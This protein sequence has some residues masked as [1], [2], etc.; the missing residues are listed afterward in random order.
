MIGKQVNNWFFQALV[1]ACALLGGCDDKKVSPPQGVSPKILVVGTSADN[2]PFET[3]REGEIVGFDLDLMKLVAEKLGVELKIQDMDLNGLI[4]ALNSGHIDVAIAA[5]T[6]SPER[7]KSVDFSRI[8][9]QGTMAL[10]FQSSAP[11]TKFSDLT[12]KKLGVQLGTTWEQF[13]RD[14]AKEVPDLEIVALNRNPQIVQELKVGRIDAVLLEETQGKAFQ[15]ANPSLKAFVI[16]GAGSSLA[17]AVRK[18]S[19]LGRE[20]DTILG[21]LMEGG[22]VKDLEKKWILEHKG[23]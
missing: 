14:Q 23:A 19:P 1:L 11:W 18:K 22:R 3:L 15:A 7:Q 10:L 9:Y 13:A 8:Y 16:P 6:P 4:P 12:G 2:P 17:I 5:L 20:I 21:A